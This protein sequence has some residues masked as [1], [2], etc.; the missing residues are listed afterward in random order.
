MKMLMNT[1][2]VTSDFFCK[3]MLNKIESLLYLF[4]RFH[5]F[6]CE[7]TMTA[8]KFGRPV[9][10][11]FKTQNK[12]HA[13]SM[14]RFNLYYVYTNLDI[15][16]NWIFFHCLATQRLFY[17]VK[18]FWRCPPKWRKIYFQMR[19]HCKKVNIDGRRSQELLLGFHC[20]NISKTKRE[21]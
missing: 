14:K 20:S 18:T 16:E 12:M 1:K 3:K 17:S 11:E 2:G 13:Y 10:Q 5:L 19:T 7:I 6:L 21:K 8:L 4:L 9:F 15:S